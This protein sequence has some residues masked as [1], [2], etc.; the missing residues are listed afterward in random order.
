MR[1]ILKNTPITRF[2][3]SYTNAD[4]T[5]KTDTQM[6]EQRAEAQGGKKKPSLGAKGKSNASKIQFL[7]DQRKP[8]VEKLPSLCGQY[9]DDLQ[10]VCD[11]DM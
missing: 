1:Y 7:L 3:I 11:V 2:E 4:G 10:L 8:P 5:R 9:D 6:E